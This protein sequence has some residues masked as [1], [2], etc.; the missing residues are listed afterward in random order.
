M[1]MRPYLRTLVAIALI[2]SAVCTAHAGGRKQPVTV[3]FYVEVDAATADPFAVPVHVGVP[4]RN[5]F[6]E[7]GASLS[8]RQILGAHVYQNRDGEWAAL[9]KLDGTGRLTL[10]NISASNRGKSL[11]AYI[12]DAKIARVLP[13]DILIDRP[14]NDGMLQVRGLLPKEA[15]LIQTHFPALKPEAPVR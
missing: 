4:Q 11:I 1:Q 14:V 3:R 9:F 6:H 15:Y 5:I 8:E 10:S 12:G 2:F 7:S 13:N